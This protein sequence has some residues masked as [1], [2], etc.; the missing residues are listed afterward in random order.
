MNLYHFFLFLSLMG[1]FHGLLM[2]FLILFKKQHNR[3]ISLYIAALLFIGSF[4]MLIITLPNAGLI[5]QY[6]WIEVL[7]NV[8]GLSIGPLLYLAVKCLNSKPGPYSILHFAPALAYLLIYFI[9]GGNFRLPILLLMFFVQSYTLVAVVQYLKIRKSKR[10]AAMKKYQRW[11]GLLLVF[12]FIMGIS[13]WV[14][15][16][17]SHYQT[18]NLII[19]STASLHLYIIVMLEFNQSFLFKNL[20]KTNRTLN[21]YLYVKNSA[22]PALHQKVIDHQLYKKEGLTVHELAH[23]LEMTAHQLSSILNQKIAGGFS[24]YINGLR[25]EFAKTLLIDPDYQHLSIE[26]IAKESGFQSRSSF[27]RFFKQEC[28]M[29]PS[30]FKTCPEF[31]NKDS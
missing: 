20:S 2:T 22:W 24:T 26:G 6:G 13:Q 28:Q 27:Y 10:S 21:D 23:H 9:S 25:I 30:A 4:G 18:L 19:P 7:E 16:S 11:L 15:F 31:E 14:R 29:T 8:L 3:L 17:F 12:F 1:V 5:P